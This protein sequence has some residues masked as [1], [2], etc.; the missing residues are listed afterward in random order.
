MKI[1]QLLASQGHGG[2]EKHFVELSLALSAWHETHCIAPEEFARYFENTPV[3]FHPMDLHGWRYR[4]ATHRRLA[5]LLRDIRPD[6]LHAQANKAAT[7]AKFHL[8]GCRTSVATIHNRKSST[9]MFGAYDGLVSVSAGAAKNV[10]HPKIRVIHNGIAPL[11]E[12]SSQKHDQLRRRL[13]DGQPLILAVGRLV[14]AKGFDLL[15]PAMKDIQARLVIA[16]TG[17]DQAVLQQ[18]IEKNEIHNVRLLG[19]RDDIPELMKACDLFVISS[20][21]EG[22]PY[23]LIEALHSKRIILS[24]PIP[25]APEFIPKSALVPIADTHSIHRFLSHALNNIDQLRKEYG[26]FHEKAQAILT[27]DNMV[28]QTTDFYELLLNEKQTLDKSRR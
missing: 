18:C 21:N 17:P 16:G 12:P 1:V 8:H 9:S 5:K 4:P 7:L 24:T 13:T 26:P 3:I 2:L 27:L 28:K 6:V 14:K 11:A 15:I 22:F 10:R 23:V 25:D 20:R 19:H